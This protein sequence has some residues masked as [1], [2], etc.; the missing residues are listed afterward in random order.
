MKIHLKTLY[1]NSPKS[2]WL[3]WRGRDALR[4]RLNQKGFY[5]LTGIDDSL[6]IYL[7][8]VRKPL[9]IRLIEK[10]LE[11]LAKICYT[12]KNKGVL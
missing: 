7:D 11:K 3:D 4:M 10:G 1:G 6:D 12:V 5:V 9:D 2:F 8:V